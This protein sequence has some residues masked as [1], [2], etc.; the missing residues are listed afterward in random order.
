[1][2]KKKLDGLIAQAKKAQQEREE[3]RA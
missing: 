3:A 2:A 1:M